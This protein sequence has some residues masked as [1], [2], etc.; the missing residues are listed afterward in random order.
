MV[1]S[2][3]YMLSSLRQWVMPVYML[4]WVRL[5]G[6]TRLQMHVR[7]FVGVFLLR[8][9]ERLSAPMANH[10]LRYF[11]LLVARNEVGEVLIRSDPCIFGQHG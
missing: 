10:G 4:S 6:E 1:E 5:M 7:L 8:P 2:D 11:S 9:W 3:L